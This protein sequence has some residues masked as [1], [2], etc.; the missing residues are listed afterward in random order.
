MLLACAGYS[1]NVWIKGKAH[2]SYAGKVI[3]AY[4]CKDYI[5]GIKQK[6]GSDT[7]DAEGY[8]E[9]AFYSEHTQPV[10][11]NVENI[12]CQIYA[13]PD[14]VYGV[15]IP[16]AEL[17][18]QKNKDV[19]LPLNMG[20]LGTDSTE[21]NALIF[22]YQEQYNRLFLPEDNRFLSRHAMFRRADSLQ[23]ICVLRYSQ[24][25]N[26]YFQ[27][28]ITYSIASINA[29][30][31][32]GENFLIGNY[33]KNH[34]IRYEH[35]EYMNFF[36]A[37]FNGYL[38]SVASQ[39]KGQTL[40]NIINTKADYSALF[41]FLDQDKNI[42]S[43]SLK[44]LV[45]L[46]DLWNLYFSPDFVPEA[47]E[48]VVSQLLLQTKIKE[49]KKIASEMMAYFTKLQVGSQ[50]PSFSALTKD[51][52]FGTLNSFKGKWIYLNFF[53]TSNVESLKEMPKIE[54]IKKKLGAK[55]VFVS[56]CLDD[57]ISSY[58]KY[59]KAN[60]KFDWPIWYNYEKTISKTA[61][62]NYA[63]VGNEAY[64]LIDNRGYLAQSPA[65]SPSRGIE[66]R[67]NSIFKIKQKTTK[68]GIR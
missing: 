2:S 46:A 25:K 35:Y 12:V 64:F 33:I 31:S 26:A 32:R 38:N 8:F 15:T 10:F 28:Y 54:A 41:K 22:D 17:D 60:P 29:S 55:M 58:K 57:S 39:H 67:L 30:V 40:F 56:V 19:E 18:L 20:V 1:Q 66:F 44:E 62:E 9:I 68:T 5:T 16:E 43:D 34:P 14:F 6:E 53:S 50:A 45:I 23:R 63:V 7:I 47:I 42:K 3:H 61:K 65:V 36:K 51:G 13:E 52:T 11:F 37:C 27:D 24:V 49:H 21:L 4:T 48:S 59:L